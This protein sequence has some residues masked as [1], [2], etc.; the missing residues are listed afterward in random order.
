VMKAKAIPLST[1]R[2]NSSPTERAVRGAK[3]F[4]QSGLRPRVTAPLAAAPYYVHL[5]AHLEA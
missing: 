2:S 3:G 5:R 4:S 1:K